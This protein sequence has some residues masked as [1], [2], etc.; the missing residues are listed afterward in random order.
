MVSLESRRGT[1]YSFQGCGRWNQCWPSMS[2]APCFLQCSNFINF[3][4]GVVGTCDFLLFNRQWRKWWE[5]T[6]LIRLPH[7]ANVL[8]WW[9]FI[10]WDSC[11]QTWKDKFIHWPWRDKLLSCDLPVEEIPWLGTMGGLRELET[12]PGSQPGIKQ[13]YPCKK[14]NSAINLGS[15]LT[16][17]FFP[18]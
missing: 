17:E 12:T 4:L 6:P 18:H 14:V 13:S 5:V 7:M 3:L 8:P 11:L 15:G 16:G 10:T 1:W 2:H 9:C